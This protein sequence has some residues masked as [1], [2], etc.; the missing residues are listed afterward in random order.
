MAH[1]AKISEQNKVLFVTPLEDKYCLDENE[2]FSEAVGQTY[3]QKHNNWPSHLWIQTSYNTD[4]NKHSSGD[5]S[6]S[7]RGNFAGIGLDWD[8]VNQ[9]FWK[10]QPFPSWTKDIATASWLCPAGPKPEITEEMSNNIQ[11]WKWDEAT[12]S[13]VV[14]TNEP[15]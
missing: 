4:E 1:F 9:I 15:A 10:P 6:K 14:V 5:N 2:N 12:T 8:P 11:N 7:F 13:W 3:L